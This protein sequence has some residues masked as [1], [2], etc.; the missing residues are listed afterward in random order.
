[1]S[2]RGPRPAALS[3]AGMVPGSV[4]AAGGAARLVHRWLAG[5]AVLLLGPLLARLFL[6]ESAP[7]WDQLTDITGLFALAA[8][9]CTVV[10]M[11]RLRALSRAA[12]ITA[13]TT[14]HRALGVL[15]AGSVLLHIAVVIAAD[16]NNLL[17][18]TWVQAPPRARAATAASIA[19]AGVIALG[20]LRHRV[21]RDYELWRWAHLVLGIAAIA[22]SALHV[23]LISDLVR[24]AAMR[25]VL[26]ALAVVLTAGLAHRALSARRSSEH[27]VREVRHDSDS[28][29][30]LVL[31]PRSAPLKFAPGQF[32]WLRLAKAGGEEHPFTI[33]SSA[34][35]GG[36]EFTVRSTGDFGTVL[37]NLPPGTPVWI[38]GPYGSCSLDLLPQPASGTAMI[39]AG[40]GITPML[41]MLRTLADRRDPRPLLLVRGAR[42]PGELLFREELAHLGHRLDLTVVEV[43]RQPPPGWSGARGDIG[44]ALLATVL[45]PRQLRGSLDYFICGGPRF[46]DDI[47]HNLRELAVP[48][49][50]IHTEQF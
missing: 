42:E 43:V 24:D 4:A 39:A 22:L 27:V 34:A 9:V 14:M 10:L 30:T 5:F 3:P 15:T 37:R 35:G 7:V 45:P 48:E 28:V 38:D 40:V 29:C 36:C 18:L 32:A 6:V 12:G 16:R 46:V 2:I 17:L 44:P 20:V 23:W 26:V 11:C 21:R 33:A 19:L 31:D 25:W 1:M 47:A 41:S 13:L 49:H 8:M 50:R